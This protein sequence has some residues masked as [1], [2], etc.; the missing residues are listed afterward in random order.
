MAKVLIFSLLFT[1]NIYAHPGEDRLSFFGDSL[2]TKLQKWKNRMPSPHRHLL[3]DK[4]YPVHLTISPSELTTP[5]GFETIQISWSGADT[6]SYDDYIAIYSPPNSSDIDYLD[7][8]DTNG[9]SEGTVHHKI[10][11]MRTDYQVRYFSNSRSELMGISNTATI[12]PHQPLQGHL[13]LTKHS[14]NE[15]QLR[16][17]SAFVNTPL[18][19]IGT[20][21]GEYTRSFTA[22]SYTYNTSKMCA[23]SAS[24]VSAKQFRDPGYMHTVIFDKLEPNTNY[25]YVFGSDA[26]W[27]N[28]HSFRI[29]AAVPP[30]TTFSFIAY[31]DMGTT[32][33]GFKF[34]DAVKDELSDENDMR[35]VLHIGDLSYARGNGYNWDKWMS[36]I[37]VLALSVPYMVSIGNHEYDHLSSVNDGGVDVSGVIGD[38]YHPSW[39]NFGD[40]S[41]GECGAPSFYRYEA[42]ICENGNSIFWYSF[43]YNSVHFVMLSSEHNYSASTDAHT[44]LLHDLE[45]VHHSATPWIIVGI[46]RPLY[47]SEIYPDDNKVDAHL[48]QLLEPLFYEYGVDVVIGGHYHSYERTCAV[49]NYECIGR[50]NGGITYFTMGA[51]G[52]MLDNAQYTPNNYILHRNEEDFGYGKFRVNGSTLHIQY[53]ALDKGVIDEVTLHKRDKEQRQLSAKQNKWKAALI[54]GFV[55]V[56]V[57][58]IAI[59]FR[60]CG[61]YMI[62]S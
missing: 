18:A 19:K 46:H 25:F 61:K 45:N 57:C 24:I 52:W 1:Q 35:L 14:P 55:V 26:L 21:S 3:S 34:I 8:F 44:F 31:G 58:A 9:A 16:W 62:C 37:A 51:A 13:S 30:Q 2:E 59:C 49:Y 38:G 56:F 32:E 28:E 22:T 17:T 4:E 40:D 29:S 42:D 48:L 11:N 23:N 50:A 33:N 10:W 41:R 15:M 60:Y 39:G 20:K 7:F 53:V 6:A 54:A 43:D 5:N 12:I 27:S 47:Q 36:M